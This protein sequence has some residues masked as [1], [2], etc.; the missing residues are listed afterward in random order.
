MSKVT[1]FDEADIL[2]PERDLVINGKTITVREFTY[3]QSLQAASEAKSFIAALSDLVNDETT[4]IDL[5]ALDGVANDHSDCWIALLAKASSK[6]ADW[7][8]G[9]NDADGN[10]LAMAFWEI[11]GPFLW[12]RVAA[13]KAVKAQIPAAAN[14]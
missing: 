10:L 5:A 11:N 4:M 14:S 8:A 9:L 3:L 1:K 6:D 12:R 2:F 7:V 13:A